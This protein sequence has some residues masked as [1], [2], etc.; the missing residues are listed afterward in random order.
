MIVLRKE[1]FYFGGSM[2][3]E[4]LLQKVISGDRQAFGQLYEQFKSKVYNTCLAYLQQENDAEEATQ[5][6]FVEVFH[7]AETFRGTA[8]VS[9][10]IY[11]IAINKCLDR[12]RY[13]NR[14][15]RFAFISSLFN[16]E[17]G[18]LMYDSPVFDHPGVKLE[19]K[20]KAAV[21]FKAI[22][23]LTENQQTAFILKHVEGLT[24]K[25]IAAIMNIGEKAVESQLSRAKDNLRKILSDFYDN[26]RRGK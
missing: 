8:S 19:N 9:T 20:E 4:E 2:L 26:D 24:Q 13:K 21:L 11:R 6:I 25:E 18:A 12:L 1:F 3:P 10:W 23:E 15:K 22:K 5:D 17:T 16:I 14:Q 7:A